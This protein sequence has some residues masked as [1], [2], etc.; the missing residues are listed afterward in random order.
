MT[1]LKTQSEQA[2]ELRLV[3]EGCGGDSPEE[4]RGSGGGLGEAGQWLARSGAA[5]RRG[6][7]GGREEL[8]SQRG[9]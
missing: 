2:R 8:V 9:R 1:K 4:K 7:P 5:W 3:R 6:S